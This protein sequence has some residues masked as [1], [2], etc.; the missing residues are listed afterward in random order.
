MSI[1][2]DVSRIVGIRIPDNGWETV[3]NELSVSGML[4]QKAI[5]N[6]LLAMCIKFEEIEKDIN[7]R[8]VE[9]TT[10]GS[11]SLQSK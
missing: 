3:F 4:D 9:R 2:D 10:K 8:E 1:R 5:V 11:S 6:V 7:A